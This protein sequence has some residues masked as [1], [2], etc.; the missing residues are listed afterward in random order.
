MLYF[1]A[2]LALIWGVLWAAF[3][4]Y[5]KFGRYLATRR[6]WI[7]VVIG[8]GVDLLIL[9]LVLPFQAWLNLS[10]VIALSSIG[11]IFRSVYNELCDNEEVMKEVGNGG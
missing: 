10:L 8:V 1:V 7:T 11:I 5:F 3:L 4:Q 9:L 6:T 2:F